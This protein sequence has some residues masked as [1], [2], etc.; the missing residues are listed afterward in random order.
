MAKAAELRVLCRVVGDDDDPVYAFA[1]ELARH[2]DGQR[3]VDRLAASHRHGIVVEDLVG[4]RVAGGD[5]RLIA[6]RPEWK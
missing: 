4:D 3:A 5:A 2:R 1:F 6:S